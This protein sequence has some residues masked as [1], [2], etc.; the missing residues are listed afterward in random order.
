MDEFTYEV[1]SDSMSLFSEEITLDEERSEFYCLILGYLC[2][3][4]C[5]SKDN[6]DVLA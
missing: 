1:I 2:K 3:I 4:S 5:L 6:Y